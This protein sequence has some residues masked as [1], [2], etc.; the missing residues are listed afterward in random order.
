LNH[1]TVPRAIVGLQELRGAWITYASPQ[2]QQRRRHGPQAR[3]IHKHTPN[4]ICSKGEPDTQ[5]LFARSRKKP[6]TRRGQSPCRRDTGAN[7]RCPT[8]MLSRASGVVYGRPSPWRALTRCRAAMSSG[9]PKPSRPPLL[10]R[11]RSRSAAGEGAHHG[12]GAAGR[13]QHRAVARAARKGRVRLRRG[14]P[15]SAR[16]GGLSFRLASTSAH[17]SRVSSRN[18]ASAAS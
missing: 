8:T 9:T 17:H 11:Q 3:L 4:G 5:P 7:G 12:R 14:R 1:F 2:T 18:A 13:H 6:R 16:L 15:K 10:P